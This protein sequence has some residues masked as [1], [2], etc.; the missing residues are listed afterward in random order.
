M[1]T[2]TGVAAFDVALRSIYHWEWKPGP[3][4][5]D[6]TP[7]PVV[8]QTLAPVLPLADAEPAAAAG[9]VV[10]APAAGALL[11]IPQV[12]FIQNCHPMPPTLSD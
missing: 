4:T 8:T 7:D 2:F 11:P 9:A 3:L 5:V 10:P 12:T 1:S 6:I